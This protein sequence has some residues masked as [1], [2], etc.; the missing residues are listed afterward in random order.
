M[1]K[2]YYMIAVIVIIALAACSDEEIVGNSVDPNALAE[3]SERDIYFMD[4]VLHA[5]GPTVYL[6]N[7]FDDPGLVY[8]I[9]TPSP[10]SYSFKTEKEVYYYYLNQGSTDGCSVNIYKDEPGVQKMKFP[11]GGSNILAILLKEFEGS[12]FIHYLWSSYYGFER[13]TGEC[14]AD[15]LAFIANCNSLG[16]SLA[17]YSEGC[18][19]EKL[20]MICIA[21]IQETLYLEDLAKPLIEECENFVDTLPEP[22]V[23]P[24]IICQGTTEGGMVCDTTWQN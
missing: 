16:G 6:N 3:L 2:K 4:S 1:N 14:S 21:K 17:S 19:T 20:E 11:R 23:E 12:Q 22:E 18:I 9:T 24:T 13:P 5:Y 10:V 15:S 7:S 8:N